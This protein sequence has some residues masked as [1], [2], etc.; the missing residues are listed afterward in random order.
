M[1]PR[2][3]GRCGTVRAWRAFARAMRLVLMT[4][5]LGAIAAWGEAPASSSAFEVQVAEPLGGECPLVG[6]HVTDQL[7][8]TRDPHQVIVY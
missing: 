8:L 7:V 2:N 4:V 3:L 1:T 5:S 6:L